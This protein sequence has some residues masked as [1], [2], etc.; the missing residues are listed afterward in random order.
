MKMDLK[1]K[2]FFITEIQM[3]TVRKLDNL[4][5]QKK[6]V[7]K[8]RDKCVTSEPVQ[9]GSKRT[10]CTIYFSSHTN[11]RKLKRCRRPYDWGFV[12]L[13]SSLGVSTPLQVM[14]C[15][16]MEDDRKSNLQSKRKSLRILHLYIFN[17]GRFHFVASKLPNT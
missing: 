7:M 17:S 1:T 3:F 15:V 16:V 6:Q 11:C 9:D 12:P 10:N 13:H 5:E 8:I 4:E 2:F 14:Q